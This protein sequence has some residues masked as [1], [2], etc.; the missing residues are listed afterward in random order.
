MT[1]EYKGNEDPNEMV[2]VMTI[3]YTVWKAESLKFVFPTYKKKKK[4]V[5][6]SV[7]LDWQVKAQGNLQT[8]SQ[9]VI[10]EV[11]VC[12]LHR[13][14]G[15]EDKVI[16]RYVNHIFPIADYCKYKPCSPLRLCKRP[17]SAS[18]WLTQVLISNP[19]RYAAIVF[20]PYITLATV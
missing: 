6:P 9:D 1:R 20:R 10:N 13:F 17:S 3:S 14:S 8:P 7:Y 15:C 19:L 2:V 18:V 12:Y 11:L 16:R 4:F 5:L